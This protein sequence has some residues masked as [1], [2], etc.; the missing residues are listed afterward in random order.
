MPSRKRKRKAKRREEYFQN[1][2]DELESSRIWYDA[3]AEQRRAS[4]HDTD[5][6]R[7]SLTEQIWSQTELLRFRGGDRKRILLRCKLLI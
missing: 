2:D 4:A 7:L 5:V 3:D 6:Q 1:Q